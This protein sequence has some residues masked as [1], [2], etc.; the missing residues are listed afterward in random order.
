MAPG[1]LA[2]IDLELSAPRQ[3]RIEGV[4]AHRRSLG[5]HDTTHRRRVPVTTIERT[6]ADLA[7]TATPATLGRL[8]DE[9]LRRRLTT[10]ERLA[11]ANRRL[12]RRPPAWRTVLAE[13]GAG[14]DPGANDWEQR[15]DRLWDQ[16]G[17]PPAVRQYRLRTG[18]RTLVIDRAVVDLRIAVEWNGREYHGTRS[19]F[20]G[21]SARRSLLVRAGWLPLDFTTRTSPAELVQ[22]VRAA[23]AARLTA[24]PPQATAPTD[25]PPGS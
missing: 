14:Y 10:T 22:T 16:A 8:V 13:R 17:L 20:D 11:A 23:V 21:D 7:V 3:V 2:G 1:D 5:R 18:G 9:A 6:L 25:G 24:T 19:G 4:T 15:M 12:A